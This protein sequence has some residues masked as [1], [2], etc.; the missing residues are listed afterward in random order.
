MIKNK[1][2]D[3]YLGKTLVGIDILIR[4]IG[5]LNSALEKEFIEHNNFKIF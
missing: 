3:K 1:I 4:K 2:L 5:V